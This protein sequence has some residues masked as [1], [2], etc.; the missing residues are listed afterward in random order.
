M[1][2]FGIPLDI[3][4][5]LFEFGAHS[6]DGFERVVLEDFLAD[7]IPEIFLRIELRRIGRKVQERDVGGNG[8]IAAAMVGSAVENQKD[9]LPGKLARQHIKE[10]LEA[11]RVR[12]RH[13]QIDAG[14]VLG[15]DRAVQIDVLAYELGGHLGPRSDR[16]PARPWPV[17][18]AEARFIGEYDAQTTSASPGRLPG[19][20]HSI[21]KA[22]FLK[23]SCAARSRLG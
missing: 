6:V 16:R 17:H 23:A 11:C 18:A 3:E 10:G 19:F 8:K 14:A 15:R 21:R 13:D 7:F 9:V 2:E 20:P 1:N 4:D 5:G 12:S 22:V